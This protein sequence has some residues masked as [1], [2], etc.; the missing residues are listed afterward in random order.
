MKRMELCSIRYDVWTEVIKRYA[1]R[2]YSLI[3]HLRGNP[4]YILITGLVTVRYFSSLRENQIIQTA[5]CI[6]VESLW[7]PRCFISLTVFPD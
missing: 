4:F 2:I 7:N 6:K 3:V 5:Y 1:T